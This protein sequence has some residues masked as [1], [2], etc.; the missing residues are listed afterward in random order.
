MENGKPAPGENSAHILVLNCIYQALTELM[1]EKE[2]REITVTELARKAGVSRM[3][4]YRNFS[5]KDDILLEHFRRRFAEAL[6]AGESSLLCGAAREAEGLARA[7]LFPEAFRI[8]MDALKERSGSPGHTPGHTPGM[9]GGPGDADA[10]ET[11]GRLLGCLWY[12]A[13]DPAREA[14][15]VLRIA[16]ILGEAGGS[17]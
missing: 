5:S 11:A 2:Y 14:E 4:C 7:G 16:R 3:A 12:A 9:T 8:V 1:R 17:T 15:G 10:A 6:E 13:G